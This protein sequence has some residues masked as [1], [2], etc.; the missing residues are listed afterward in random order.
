MND[1]FSVMV[2]LDLSPPTI[3]CFEFIFAPVLCNHVS[4]YTE[5]NTYYCLFDATDFMHFSSCKY[6]F[7]LRLC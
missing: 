3:Y 1:N 5:L 7:G 6:K 2:E 4:N